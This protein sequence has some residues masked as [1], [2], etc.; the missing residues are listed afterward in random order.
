M[1]LARNGYR[2]LVVDRA[3]FPSDTLS[4]H[5]VHPP[6][7]AALQRWGILD[8]LVATGCPPIDTYVF[9]FETVTISGAPGDV[10]ATVA[11][12]PRR[13][14]LDALLVDAARQAG[15]RYA[16]SSPL[17]N[18]S[19]KTA[20]SS[21]SAGTER[22]GRTVDRARRCG[23]GGGRSL[24]ARRPHRGAC[25][26]SREATVALRL[27]LV[28]EQPPDAR[29]LRA[30]PRPARGFAAAPTNDGLTLVI[31]GWDIAH[32]EANKH[33]IEGNYLADNRDGTRVR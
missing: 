29:T 12:C 8:K 33:D 10:A 13:T 21:A 15:G 32:C 24:L 7:V 11:Y 9:D 16:R 23:S 28:L 6:A 5:I 25:A 3:K 27:L 22:G 30:I 17:T 18:S 4:T 2:V 20:A 14:V 26:V 1:L 19:S 31:A